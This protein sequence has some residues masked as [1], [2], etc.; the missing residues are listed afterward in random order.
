MKGNVS[1]LLVGASFATNV[2]T[3]QVTTP[4]LT[5]PFPAPLARAPALP[6]QGGEGLGTDWPQAPSDA[7]V[8]SVNNLV[9]LPS[10]QHDL[11]YM[12]QSVCSVPVPVISSVPVYTFSP[13]SPVSEVSLLCLDQF[14]L[15]LHHHPDRSAV[16][17]MISGIQKGFRIGF[18]ASSVSLKSASFNMRSSS[19]WTIFCGYGASIRATV[20]AV[21]FH[22]HYRPG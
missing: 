20:S 14:Q 5:A 7:C 16:A 4:K 2:A 17:Y 11:P 3:V 15:E 12:P 13:L 21:Y 8:H 1:G 18:E 19:S 9:A 10:R 22:L 6:P